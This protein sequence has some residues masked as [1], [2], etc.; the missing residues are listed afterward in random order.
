MILND[1]VDGDTAIRIAGYTFISV[2]VGLRIGEGARSTQ[3]QAESISVNKRKT[4]SES[5]P[6]RF[7]FWFEKSCVFVCCLVC[8]TRVCVTEHTAHSTHTHASTTQLL[9]EKVTA[10]S[11]S[12]I[13][14]I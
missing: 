3:R 5:S 8:V 11:A 12:S 10:L 4:A 1:G 9:E 14:K 13:L 2:F 7:D 6:L